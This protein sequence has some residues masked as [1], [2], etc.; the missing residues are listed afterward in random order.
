[1]LLLALESEVL[2]NNPLFDRLRAAVV[3]RRDAAFAHRV[4]LDLH[5]LSNPISPTRR[6]S[7]AHPLPANVASSQLF[8]IGSEERVAFEVFGETAQSEIIFDQR[9]APE[10]QPRSDRLMLML[11]LLRLHEHRD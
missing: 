3:T 7:V 5:L 4:S 2:L 8:S 6:F 10:I 11:M 9:T 1:M